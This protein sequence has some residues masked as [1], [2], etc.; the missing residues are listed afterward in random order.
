MRSPS[1]S[2]LT[3]LSNAFIPIFSSF[4]KTRT[5]QLTYAIPDGSI[6]RE[7]KVK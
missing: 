2:A 3:K 4:F 7:L 6:V 1:D 5:R